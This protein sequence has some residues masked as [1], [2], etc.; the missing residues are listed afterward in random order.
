MEIKLLSKSGIGFGI[1]IIVYS[2]VRWNFLY[3]DFSQLIFG[4]WIGICF[5]LFSYIYNFLK[6]IK[7][8]FEEIDEANNKRYDYLYRKMEKIENAEQKF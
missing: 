1:F 2:I 6:N 8:E 4:V 7:K 3:N 5:C